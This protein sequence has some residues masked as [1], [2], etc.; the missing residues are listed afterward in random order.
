MYLLNSSKGDQ[1]VFAKDL[2]YTSRRHRITFRDIPFPRHQNSDLLNKTPCHLYKWN[3]PLITSP[4]LFL[5]LV[6]LI[7]DQSL[8][9]TIVVKDRDIEIILHNRMW[10]KKQSP[11][12]N[13]KTLLLRLLYLRIYIFRTLVWEG[14]R[15]KVGRQN[16]T[17]NKKVHIK[18]D[19]TSLYKSTIINILLSCQ[20]I[21]NK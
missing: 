1:F 18:N 5:R 2:I 7:H 9:P 19:Y 15:W 3:L 13:K 17:T 16:Q 20:N 14:Y 10:Q 4:F 12:I 8:W 6:P 11:K 21:F